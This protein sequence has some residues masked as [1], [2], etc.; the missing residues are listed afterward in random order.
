MSII[1]WGT[2]H[3]PDKLGGYSPAAVARL[4]AF[5]DFAL[6]K[7]LE[8]TPQ[9]L[10]IISGMAQGWDQSL[11]LACIKRGVPFTAAIPFESQASIWPA[12]AQERWRHIR[13]RAN[14]V[15]VVTQGQPTD[16]RAALLNRNLWMRDH[17]ETCW[18]LWNGTSGGTSH[19]VRSARSA[20]QK[21]LNFWSRWVEFQQGQLPLDLS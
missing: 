13:S 10:H 9:G 5:A 8:R 21:V 16:F 3:R 20:G 6:G 19:G 12:P 14:N 15:V 4:D 18:A 17:A 2:G 11:A 7:M 1:A